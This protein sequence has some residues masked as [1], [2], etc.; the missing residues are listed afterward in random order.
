MDT[1]E[2][3]H[4]K[5]IHLAIVAEAAARVPRKMPSYT[6]Y[7]DYHGYSEPVSMKHR[8]YHDEQEYDGP[9]APLDNEVRK[10]SYIL[11]FIAEISYEHRNITK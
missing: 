1:P 4:A 8:V 11:M 7:K 6:D 10:I 3:A 2:V 5:A 9:L